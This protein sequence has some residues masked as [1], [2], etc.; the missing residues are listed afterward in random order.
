MCVA[1]CSVGLEG[2]WTSSC[3]TAGT[4]SPPAGG[5][6]IK[7]CASLPTSVD[8]AAW[9]S[10]CRNS[11]FGSTCAARCSKGYNGSYTATC[12]EAGWSEP[13][14]NCVLKTC[15]AAPPPVAN[16]T[17]EA[18]C[19]GAAAF[20]SC[21]GACDLGFSG[22][23]SARCSTVASWSVSGG[24]S[25]NRCASLPASVDNA[26]WGRACRNVTYG[27][28]C[29]A[30]CE[31]GYLGDVSSTCGS[32]GRWAEPAGECVLR[33]CD[34][35]PPPVNDPSGANASWVPSCAGTQAF[36]MCAATC[37]EDTYT[38]GWTSDC[39]ADGSWT[40]PLGGCTLKTCVGLPPSVANVAWASGC[41]N[42]PAG[43]SCIADCVNGVSGSY[44]SS[45]GVDAATG[46]AVWSTPQGSCV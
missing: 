12:A 38:G 22:N 2:G 10:R 15:D 46:A 36:G 39:G 28:V 45:C 17:W 33:T 31:A 37:D 26:V 6:V 14:G 44:S 18:V 21:M 4:W 25:I 30:A 32:D 23:I 24:C 1:N 40:A 9:P 29:T 3:S 13:A 43:F 42:A 7:R 11:T 20:T 5:C 19:V 16:A 41:A 27:T 8:N 35:L 34:G